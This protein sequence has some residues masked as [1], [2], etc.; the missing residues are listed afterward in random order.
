MAIRFHCDS[1]AIPRLH[2]FFPWFLA[3]NKSLYLSHKEIFVIA[4]EEYT[5]NQQ[6]FIFNGKFSNMAWKF[7][8]FPWW[9][10]P[11]YFNIYINKQ[12][13]L[14]MINIQDTNWQNPTEHNSKNFVH[15]YNSMC[16]KTVL[17]HCFTE[18]YSRVWFFLYWLWI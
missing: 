11:N 15:H 3:I 1:T 8:K 4:N 5:W 16:Q 9:G 7:P 13:T 14:S 12:H 6:N 18:P 2:D 10:S 17:F